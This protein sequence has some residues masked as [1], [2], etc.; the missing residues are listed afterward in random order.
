LGR[1]LDV[2]V[3][4]GDLLRWAIESAVPRGADRDL[5]PFHD[6]TIWSLPLQDI[7]DRRLR[8]ARRLCQISEDVLVRTH[9]LKRALILEGV[10]VLPEFASQR[11]YGGIE[12]GEKVRSLFLYEPDIDALEQRLFARD[13]EMGLPADQPSRLE[14]LH[15]YGALIKRGAVFLG[16]PVLES[17]PFDTLLDRALEVLNIEVWT[18]PARGQS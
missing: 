3:Q 9:Y 5:H 7:M 17:Q 4:Q 13:G 14:S 11:S 2:P 12:M 15:Q 16:L 10:W 1:H 6:P 8:W 18:P